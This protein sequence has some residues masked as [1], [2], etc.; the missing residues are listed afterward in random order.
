MQPN[1]VYTDSDGA[2]VRS[3]VDQFERNERHAAVRSLFETASEPRS[4]LTSLFG[5][6]YDSWYALVADDIS[7]H[8]LDCTPGW[9][10][11]TPLL[12]ALADS[13]SSYQPSALGRRLFESR[14]ELEGSDVATLA[15]DDLETAIDGRSF[16]TIVTTG[17]RPPDRD[18][19]DHIDRL[20]ASLADG[21]TLVTEVNGWPRTSG[22]TDLVGLGGRSET[23]DRRSPTDVWRSIPSRVVAALE[24]CG[25]EEVDLIGLLPGG[26]QYR[27]AVPAEDPDALEWVLETITAE[28]T[29]SRLLRRGAALASELG[30]VAQSYPS[31][32]AVCRTNPATD[33]DTPSLTGTDAT[34]VLRRGANRSIIFELAENSVERVRKVPNAPQHARYNER[35]A[36]TLSM[37][38]ES[39]GTIAGTLPDAELESSPLGPVLSESPAPGTPLMDTTTRWESPPDPD[40]F[41]D[42]L[43]TG[44]RWIRTIQLAHAGPRRTRSPEAVRRE[45]SPVEF[46][47]DPP[48]VAE[49]VEYPVVPAHGDYHPGNVLVDADGSIERVIDWEYATAESN[50]V[51][52][53]AFFTLKLAEFAFGGFEA[54]VRTALLEETPYS[55]RVAESIVAYCDALGIRPRTFATYLGH[56]FVSQTDVHFETGSPWRFHANPREKVE[57]LSVLYDEFDEILS[58][59]ADLTV[60]S[61][62]ED[63]TS[64]RYS[65]PVT[66]GPEPS[67]SSISKISH[68]K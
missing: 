35:A 23:A 12:R 40:A 9:G 58:R 33:S 43:E 26:S 48:S 52:D 21:G 62:D 51:T 60:S 59:L 55:I 67:N 13:V 29:A 63:S 46:D 3:F 4:V 39:D 15:G 61:T 57:R 66:T 38:T 30:V 50:P 68:N 37:L 53:P 49:P 6:G 54:G 25:F 27:W 19:V 20:T 45:L 44:L 2:A 8:C 56:T 34:R 32:V 22:V 65:R 41:V 5:V 16:D 11:T 42:V 7:G 47:V 36:S 64:R 17:S 28:T 14:P 24:A 1:P 31:Y 18:F 10:R